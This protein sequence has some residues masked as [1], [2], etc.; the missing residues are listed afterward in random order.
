MADA[1][2]RTAMLFP[3]Q[4]SS[5]YPRSKFLILWTSVAVR[6]KTSPHRHQEKDQDDGPFTTGGTANSAAS[7]ATVPSTVPAGPPAAVPAAAPVL[8]EVA[9]QKR[10][11]P[12]CR[13]LSLLPDCRRFCVGGFGFFGQ[14]DSSLLVITLYAFVLTLH[15]Y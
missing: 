5:P 14:I 15:I 2:N 13:R 12:R 6:P 10:K 3:L 11:P 1:W 7:P 9:P 4:E 8:A